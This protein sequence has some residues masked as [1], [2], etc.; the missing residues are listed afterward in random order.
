MSQT[1]DS[2]PDCTGCTDAIGP[3]RRAFLRDAA[4]AV[5]AVLVALGST[6]LDAFARP[7]AFVAPVATRAQTRAYA[8]PAAD[9]AQIDRENEVIL[10]RWQG[11]VYAFDLSCPHQHTALRWLASDT[12]FQCPKHK[13]KYRP[14]GSFIEGRATRNMDRFGVRRDGGNVVVDLDALHRS[15]EDPS[16]WAAA[17]VKV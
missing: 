15:D 10:A 3:D 12:R 7:L 1:H 8:V 6:P 5:G 9:G 11:A 14:D 4:A 16:G 13:S 2:A 17:V